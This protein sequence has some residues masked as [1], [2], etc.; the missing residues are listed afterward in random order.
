MQIDIGKLKS[1]A[2]CYIYDAAKIEAQCNALRNALAEFDILYSV[3]TNPFAGVLQQVR[4]AGFGLDAASATEVMIGLTHGFKAEDIFYS[5][6]G[7]SVEDIERAIGRCRIIVDSVN[8]LIRLARCARE[9][10]LTDCPFGMRMHPDFGLAGAAPA[11]SKFGIELDDLPMVADILRDNP[12]LRF[13]GLHIHLKSQILD[14]D[15]IGDY[16]D[17][18]LETAERIAGRPG[19][20][21]KYL[22][23]GSGIGVA[24]DAKTQK[25]VDLTRLAERARAVQARNRAG[26]DTR[27]IVE[28]GRFIV[29]AA[30]GFYTPVEDIKLSRGVKYLIVRN[31][32]NGFLRPAVAHMIAANNPEAPEAQEPFYSTRAAF[33]ADVINDAAEREVVSIVGNLCTELDVVA[34]GV[35][36]RRAELGDLVRISNAG[37]YAFTLSPV[38]F[39]GQGLPRQI[40]LTR[41]GHFLDESGLRIDRTR[42]PQTSHFNEGIKRAILSDV[43]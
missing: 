17:R 34:E 38:L 7:K 4:Q 41:D 16:W 29:S 23:L 33:E 2:P 27:L 3:K 14:A 5:A 6:P 37:G 26:L 12:V 25:P 18:C 20:R 35:T 1:L 36:V 32:M 8:E 43:Q 15:Q 11:P 39:S 30:G 21:P 24:Y 31:G 22:N 9:Q 40:L 10:G 42:A 19:M 28:S 13:E